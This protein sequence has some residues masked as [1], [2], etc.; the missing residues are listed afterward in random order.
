MTVHFVYINGNKISCP[1][2]IGRNVGLRLRRW[3]HR[4]VYY[5]W[6]DFRKIKPRGDDDVL[7][8]HPNY[9]P[10]TVYRRSARLDGWRRRIAMFPFAHGETGYAAFA[11]S[12]V[13]HSDLV[14]AIAGRYWLQTAPQSLYAHW[15]PK[16]VHQDLA[17]DRNDFPVIKHRFNPPGRRR[18]LYIGHTGTY[19]NPHFLS[20]IALAMPDIDFSWLGGTYNGIMLD[21]FKFLGSYD[22][23][24]PAAHEIIAGHDFL[25]TVGRSDPNPTTILEA[26]AWGLIPVCTPQSG[27]SDYP[28]I[29]NVPLD[30][31]DG[32]VRVL[33]E[34]QEMPEP[35]LEEMRHENW[36]MLDT[37]FNWDRFATQ[38]KDA[39]ESDTSPP[40]G[41]EPLGR[42]LKL[43]AASVVTEAS[44]WRPSRLARHLYRTFSGRSKSD[45]TVLEP[46]GSAHGL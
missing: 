5:Q 21:R 20:R 18:V 34:L 4:V 6:D 30:D 19:K 44:P 27:Y 31:V 46:I 26:M 29:P 16:L 36:R 45:R 22:F 41:P 17:V 11:D 8:G 14:L 32:A 13:R 39:I 3:G 40:L 10:F 37:H 42:K 12:A 25:L 7:L 35:R 23:S 9:A 38:V 24:L 28:S 1:Q 2:A 33:R 43:M 15:C